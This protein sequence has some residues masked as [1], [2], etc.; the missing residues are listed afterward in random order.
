[1]K[2]W[3]V[4]GD[5]HIGIEQM[6]VGRAEFIQPGRAAL[7][8]HLDQHDDVEAQLA[9]DIQD[10]FQGG[11]IDCVLTLIVCCAAAVPCLLYTSPSPRDEL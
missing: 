9:T 11:E 4:G 5:E 10:R 3:P 7:F 8:T 1:M 2:A 6:L